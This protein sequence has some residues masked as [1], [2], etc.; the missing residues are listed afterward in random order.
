MKSLETPLKM[1]RRLMRNDSV[2]LPFSEK[3]PKKIDIVTCDGCQEVYCSMQ[4]KKDASITYHQVLCRGEERIDFEALFELDE[5]W[6]NIHYP[7][8]TTTINIIIKIIA[9]YQQADDKQKVISTLNGFCNKSK[10]DYSSIS[11][12]LLGDQFSEN[13]EML[14][15]G[16]IKVFGMNHFLTEDNFTKMLAMLGTNQQGIGT[17][18][19]HEWFKNLNKKEQDDELVEEF[20]DNLYE[21]AGDFLDCDGIGLYKLQSKCN[22]SCSPNSQVSFDYGNFRLSLK[23]TKDISKDEEITISYISECKLRRSRYSRQK[24]LKEFYLFICDCSKCQLQSSD[25]NITS[26]SSSD[27]S[28]DED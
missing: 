14:R 1:S 23:A 11:H 25:P 20:Y 24:Y 19:I 8:E 28:S 18:S 12:H 27:Q 16:L 10:N 3:S 2:K 15:T 6:R 21:E 4:C 22:H 13:I 7:P 26:S 9:L 5:I 17:S